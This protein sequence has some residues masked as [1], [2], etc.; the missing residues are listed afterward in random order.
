MSAPFIVIPFG[1]G[2]CFGPNGGVQPSPTGFLN[3]VR[4]R[5]VIPV[6]YLPD[7]SPYLGWAYGQALE[8]VNPLLQSSP[9][10]PGTYAV[11]T[12]AVY[13]LGAHILIEL[14]QDVAYPIGAASWANG[15][16][17]LTLTVQNSVQP[18]DP[19][20]VSGISPV[21]YDAAPNK[22]VIVN[23]V[24][25][26][27]NQ[28]TYVISPNPGPGSVLAGAQVSELYFY[29]ARAAFGINRVSVGVVTSAGDQGTSTGL[30]NPEFMQNLTLA[31]LQYLKTPYGQ[32][33]VS[34]AQRFGRLWGLT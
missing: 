3:F 16:A 26:G 33:Y 22:P 14:A 21:A 7:D 24:T 4:N 12:Q 32:A 10:V 27:V 11:Y 6:A 9:G 18:G 23:S 8:I 2:A 28:I 5:V 19:I 34:I 29:R 30:L 15:L 1:P 13:N 20:S 31:D 17:T 25:P